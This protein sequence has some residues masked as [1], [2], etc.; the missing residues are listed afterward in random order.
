MRHDYVLVA[1]WLTLLG[2]CIAE[3]TLPDMPVADAGTD[4]ITVIGSR[5]TLDGAGSYDPAGEAL[6]YQWQLL[7]MPGDADTDGDVLRD[8]QSQQPY[9]DATTAGLYVVGLRVLAGKRVSALDSVAVTARD[10][11]PQ[12]RPPLPDAGDDTRLCPGETGTLI[13]NGSFD[14]DGDTLTSYAWEQVATGAVEVTITGADQINASFIAPAATPQPLRFRLTVS[15]GALTASDTVDVQVQPVV[16]RAQGPQ[17]VISGGGNFTLDG[18]ASCYPGGSTPVWRWTQHEQQVG[19]AAVPLNN[20]TQAQATGIAPTGVDYTF[21][22]ELMLTADGD[23]D[24]D[25][26]RVTVSDT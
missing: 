16:A 14:P 6:S 8:S 24:R 25:T 4:Q 7:T 15:D 1:S 2:G 18:T 10:T 12:N 26:T 17:T 19:E 13:G 9:F 22:F 11:T 20:V 23:S 3:T 21:E 5:V